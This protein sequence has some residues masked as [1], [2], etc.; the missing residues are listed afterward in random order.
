MS[1][2]SPAQRHEINRNIRVSIEYPD[3]VPIVFH[4]FNGRNN[5]PLIL[6]K[7]TAK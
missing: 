6:L 7:S 2:A 4:V 5:T 1:E 3:S